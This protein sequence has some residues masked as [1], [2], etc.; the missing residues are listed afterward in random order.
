MLALGILD[1]C[2]GRIPERLRRT[3]I[4][5]D[6]VGILATLLGVGGVYGA[7]AIRTRKV[8]DEMSP[9]RGGITSCFRGDRG[10]HAGPAGPVR[11]ERAAVAV[12]GVL[13]ILAH[14][15]AFVSLGAALGVWMR[16]RRAGRS[17]RAS[18]WS[19]S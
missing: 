16:R 8:L 19:S 1:G 6:V 2:F 13:T 11:G 7:I 5:A 15:A 10:G 17:P 12:V 14:G 18:A 9:L 4:L 3:P